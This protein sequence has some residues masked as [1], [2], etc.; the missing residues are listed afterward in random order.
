MHTSPVLETIGSLMYLDT[1]TGSRATLYYLGPCST[2]TSQKSRSVSF[3]ALNRAALN[4]STYCIY[5][6]RRRWSTHLPCCCVLLC[7]CGAFCE[8]IIVQAELKS[9]HRGKRKNI[10]ALCTTCYS[11]VGNNLF[12]LDHRKVIHTYIRSRQREKGRRK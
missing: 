8:C 7:Y 3:S 11:H 6:Y 10:R 12:L 1:R 4:S 5:L 2:V 9:V